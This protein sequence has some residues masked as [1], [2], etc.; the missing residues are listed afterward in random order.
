M[1]YDAPALFDQS[2]QSLLFKHQK[3]HPLQAMT[4]DAPT[5]FDQ[6]KQ[7][8][9]FKHQKPH[10]LQV[11]TYD[12]PALFDQSDL[13]LSDVGVKLFSR[14]ITNHKARHSAAH[15][16]LLFLRSQVIQIL[17]EKREREIYDT[18]SSKW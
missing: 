16:T 9:L 12:A 6:S 4:Y 1:T 15:S 13:F 5:L 18:V 11:M 7:S 3:P 2:K 14:L 10:P 17:E 8:L